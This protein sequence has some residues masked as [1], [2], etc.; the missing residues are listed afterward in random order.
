M[1]SHV[2]Q[3]DEYGTNVANKTV[4]PECALQKFQLSNKITGHNK[5][6]NHVLTQVTSEPIDPNSISN[7]EYLYI[8]SQDKC[9]IKNSNNVC[10]DQWNSCWHDY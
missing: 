7:D 1:Q 8:L 5:D 6:N 9:G 10:N 2:L 3:K 4:L